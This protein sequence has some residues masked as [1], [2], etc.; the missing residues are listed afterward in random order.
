MFSSAAGPFSQP[1]PSA[2]TAST[3]FQRLKPICVELLSLSSRTP[4][5][6]STQQT[7]ACLRRLKSTLHTLLSVSAIT[8]PSSHHASASRLVSQDEDPTLPP[9]LINYV[10]YPLSELISSAP[11]GLTSLP[12][13]VVEGVLEVLALLCSR[14]WNAS[15]ANDGGGKGWQIWCDLVILSSSVLGESGK[16]GGEAKGTSSDEAKLAALK[17]LAELLSPRSKVSQTAGKEKKREEEGWEW[18]G[19]SDLPSLDDVLTQP[20]LDAEEP[21]KGKEIPEAHMELLFPTSGHL[22]YVTS[23]RVAKGAI[24]FVLFSCFAIAESSQETT[25]VRTAAMR[26]AK[27]ALLVWIGGA[28]PLPSRFTL[29]DSWLEVSPLQCV[30]LPSSPDKEAARKASAMRLRPLL[31]G[32]TSSLTRLATSRLKSQPE[33]RKQKP[34]PSAVVTESISML[35]DLLRA[36]LA[37]ECLSE[38]LSNDVVHLSRS[39]AGESAEVKVTSLEDFAHFDTLSETGSQIATPEEAPQPTPTPTD[40]AGKEVQWTLST[41]AQVHLALKT[42]SSLTSP[43]LAGTS[44]PSSTHSTV[45]VSM[46]RLSILL[47]TDCS[48]SFGWL[49][50][51][52]QTMA[53]LDATNTNTMDGGKSI[54]TILTWI[55]DLASSHNSAPTVRNAKLAFEALQKGGSGFEARLRDGSALWNIL[56]AALERLPAV[57]GARDD[58]AVSR[59]VLRVSTLLSLLS[60]QSSAMDLASLAMIANNVQVSSFRLLRPLKVEQLTYTKDPTPDNTNPIWRLQPSFAGLESS[61]SRQ[62]SQMFCDLGRSLALSLLAQVKCNPTVTT[63]KGKARDA[64]GMIIT[65]I[66]RAGQL[67][68]I[69]EDHNDAG[70][71]QSAVCLVVAADMARGVAT[72]LD[73]MRLGGGEVG[74]QMRKVAHSLGKRVFGLV[75]DILDGDAEEASSSFLAPSAPEQ[76]MQAKPSNDLTTRT[77]ADQEESL[78]ENVKGISLYPTNL[79]SSTPSRLGPVLDLAFVRF[80]DLTRLNSTTSTQL[81]V[82]QRHRQ[83]QKELDLSNSL[84]FSLLSSSS[85]LLGQSF[86]PLL[87]RGAYPLISAISISSTCTSGLVQ[88]ASSA[89]MQDIAFNTAYGDVKNCLLDHAD[90]ILGSACQRLIGGLDEELRSFASEGGGER[91]GRGVVVPLVSAQRAPFVLVEMIRVLGSEVVPMVEDA[92]DEVL[93]ALDRFHSHEGV[94]DGLL[95]VLGGI[96]ECMAAEQSTQI[97]TPRASLLENGGGER[98]EVEDFKSWLAARREDSKA[99][100]DVPPTS[101]GNK[102]RKEDE[103]EDKPTK[104]QQVS[105]TI[106]TKSTFFLT[107]PSPSLRIRVLHLLRHGILTLAPQSRTAELLPIINSAWPFVMTRLGTPYS[108]STSPLGSRLVPIIDLTPTAIGAR[109]REGDARWFEKMEKEMVEKDVGVWVAAAK[110]V[111]AAVEWVPDFVRK[112]VLDDAWPRFEVLLR[113]MK[114]FDPRYHHSSPQPRG[115]TCQLNG[116]ERPALLTSEP[117]PTSNA[118]LISG[119]TSV[120]TH[121]AKRNHIHTHS[122]HPFIHPSITTL[123][124]Q[125]TLCIITTLTSIVRHLGSHMSDDV[126]WAITTHSSFLEALDARQPPGLVRAAEE[127]YR[128]LRKRNDEA[129]KWVLQCAFPHVKV[130]A[131]S[132]LERREA[133]PCFMAQARIQVHGATMYCVLEGM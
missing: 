24:S 30:H 58:V 43:S 88:Q 18:D 124:A 31:P 85:R 82:Q 110:Y 1:G 61:T 114:R 63:K 94:S 122:E 127:L 60:E 11:K 40:K 28:C 16:A 59:L 48:R 53:R 17:V 86:R 29:E 12:D 56:I 14:W 47:L 120:S 36:T 6:T 32:I 103:E 34:T 10:F 130:R 112:R 76:G 90:Y 71:E 128:E 27:D 96:M 72:V 100:D 84:L 64:F 79:S 119:L 83:A 121:K 50:T 113:L 111:E 5:N 73:N 20:D 38:V 9:S 99:F 62:F 66:T 126:A 65:L 39:T 107:S 42:F 98:G 22:A 68:S 45:Q 75:M 74:R 46:L 55:V 21:S 33:A 106:L 25:E 35:G 81:S 77:D 3:P 51:Q 19:I 129:T 54:E 115:Q 133:I 70:R 132:G 117:S 52:L 4:S 26:V 109:V 78:V 93:D 116:S 131:E 15:S 87:Q 41:L 95:G 2:S 37:D 125:L 80:A 105:A 23:E 102:G 101:D 89:A 108:T 118:G 13:S 44:L 49:D 92:I 67:R 8:G 69:R 57:V 97:P 7:I 104:S 123:P 91:K